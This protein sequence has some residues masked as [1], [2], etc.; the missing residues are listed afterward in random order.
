MLLPFMIALPKSWQRQRALASR[1]PRMSTRTARYGKSQSVA[2]AQWEK[3]FRLRILRSHQPHLPS[4]GILLF[5]A[6]LA[7]LLKHS[8]TE[9]HIH[10][11][12]SHRDEASA[13]LAVTNQGV[14]EETPSPRI[15]HPL[16]VDE[17]EEDVSC[18]G[19]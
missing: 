13:H 14:C 9:Y 16:R 19:L 11:A 2:G 8:L 17:E 10:H 12:D 18:R 15:V 1:L 6:L 5:V 4:I 7:S 3:R